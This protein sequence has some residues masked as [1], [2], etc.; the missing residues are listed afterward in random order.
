MRETSMVCVCM[1]VCA[2]FVSGRCERGREQMPSG[3]SGTLQI[4]HKERE[5]SEESS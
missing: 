2:R 5:P 3:Q 1:C 4:A